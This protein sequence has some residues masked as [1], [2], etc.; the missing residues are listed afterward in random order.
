MDDNNDNTKYYA[1]LF[2]ALLVIGIGLLV[3]KFLG[4]I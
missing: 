4:V 3:V 2:V 1:L